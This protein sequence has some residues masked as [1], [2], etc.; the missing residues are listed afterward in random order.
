MPMQEQT[1]VD[2]IMHMRSQIDLLWQVFVTVQLALFALIMIYD[3]AVDSL[4]RL[5]RTLALIG[6]GIFSY[7]NGSALKNAYDLLAAL[8]VQYKLDY[9][10]PGRFHDGLLKAFVNVDFSGRE[11]M[12]L[13]THGL[14][15]T[16]VALALIV[17][18]FVQH[19]QLLPK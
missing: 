6:L 13:L 15:F 4:N 12:I 18:S 14:A 19:R 2:A 10:Q 16:V 3:E 7:I 1:M 5:A 17:P 9:G 11:T 8:H